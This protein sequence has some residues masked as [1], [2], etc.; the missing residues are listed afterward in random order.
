MVT[1][2]NEREL[3]VETAL[4]EARARYHLESWDNYFYF[5]HMQD[6]YYDVADQVTSFMTEGER[7]TYEW[8]EFPRWFCDACDAY[9]TKHFGTNA[10]EHL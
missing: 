6:V 10:S 3:A 8:G 7:E 9:E 5:M 1:M 2:M 4:N